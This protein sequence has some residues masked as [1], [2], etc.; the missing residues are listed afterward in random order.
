MAIDDWSEVKAEENNITF[1]ENLAY[2]LDDKLLDK[3]GNDAIEGFDADV[4]SRTDFDKRRK[5]WLKLF[6]GVRDPKNTPWPNASNTHIPLMAYACLQFQARA[7]EALIPSKEIVKCYTGDSKYV[8]SARRVEN[9]MNYQLTSGMEDWLEDMDSSL[10]YLPMMGSIYKKT[11]Y[12]AQ[13]KTN[14]SGY[15]GVED[16][17]TNYGARKLRD[18]FR[19]THILRVK[20]SDMQRRFISRVWKQWPEIPTEASSDTS[21][22]AM[23]MPEFQA[24]KDKIEGRQIPMSQFHPIREVLE[25]HTELDGM[26]FNPITKKLVKDE[27][28]WG[29]PFVIWVDYETRKVLRIISRTYYSF[30]LKME[31]TMEFFTQFGLIPNPDSHYWYGFGHLVDHINETADTILNQLIDAGHLSN[32][33]GGFVSKRMGMKGKQIDW[34][35][36]KFSELDILTDDIRK[37]VMTFNFRPPSNVLFTLLGLLQGYVKDVTSTADWMSGAM[38]PSDTAATTMLAVIEQG[39][40]VFSTIQKRCH[41]SFGQELKKIYL[42]N[43]MNLDEKVYYLVQDSNSRL[44]KTMT[45]GKA[46]YAST[47]EIIPASDPNITSKAETLIKTQQVLSSVRQSPLTKENMKSHYIAEKNYYEALGVQ[48]IDE[49]LPEPKPE[50]PQDISPIEENS[51]F[52]NE[53]T[54]V[55]LPQQDHHG[56]FVLHKA[57][58]ESSTW[59]P[60]LTPLAKGIVESHSREHLAMAYKQEEELKVKMGSQGMNMPLQGGQDGGQGVY[61]PG[62]E[63]GMAIESS[64][65]T[66]LDEFRRPKEGSLAAGASIIR[67]SAEFDAEG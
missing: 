36:G 29:E 45:T 50:Q 48:N 12:D 7:M 6:A 44:A 47:I 9:H 37:A 63:E 19:K 42:L 58:M 40:K 25:V 18:C 2:N 27:K 30:E 32:V 39:L 16:F 3:I 14:I 24:E 55:V 46:D 60:Y 20:V 17:V 53:R 10:M 61:R 11:Y 41:R 52:I 23:P 49:I 67:P 15:V 59:A 31:K 5:G 38:P 62:S 65:E 56:H 26:K 34:A 43:S 22:A 66:I 4:D 1:H 51:M 54:S 33:Q 35:M 21:K 8:D 28:A 57:L 13:L 64:D